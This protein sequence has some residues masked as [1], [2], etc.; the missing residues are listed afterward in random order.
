MLEQ[1]ACPWCARWDEEIG[2]AYPKTEEGRI[3]P[4]RRVSI[5]DPWPADLEGI[6]RERFTPVFVLVSDGKEYGRI[7][8]YPGADFFWPMLGELI[9]RL[10]PGERGDISQ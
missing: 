10:P 5:R 2:V 6:A 4:L 1:P 9:A 7:R 8:G 3:A